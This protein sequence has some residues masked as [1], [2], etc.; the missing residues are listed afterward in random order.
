MSNKKKENSLSYSQIF[1]YD[2]NESIMSV[3]TIIMSGN[4][5]PLASDASVPIEIISKS[6]LVANR[7]L[8]YKNLFKI[9]YLSDI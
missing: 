9:H 1:P 8:K 2:V 7:N 3:N 4:V 5:A 6:N